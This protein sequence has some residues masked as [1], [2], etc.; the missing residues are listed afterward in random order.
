MDKHY[1]LHYREL[2]ERHWWWRAREELV[3]ATLERWRP[4]EGWR[5]IL[6]VGCGDGLFFEKLSPFGQV[7]G[8]EMDPTGIRRDGPWAERIRIG[9]FDESFQPGKKYSLLLMLDVLE[10]FQDPVGALGRA[11]ALLEPHGRILLT[12]PAF[13][14]LWTSHD[15]LNHHRTRYTRRS[16]ASL[17]G[18]AGARI[19]FSRY[20]FRWPAPV[21]LAVRIKESLFGS[22]PTTPQVP[23]NWLNQALYGISRGEEKIL[24][25]IPLPFG[26][27]LLAIASRGDEAF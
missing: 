20:F 8:I 1:A 25:R 10:H 22:H 16:L 2:Y 19:L 13:L 11:L 23:P 3:L 6:D 24:G 5:A 17:G 15:E 21:K 7:E 26:S 18:Q 12:V 4:A 27:S 9:P 14:L